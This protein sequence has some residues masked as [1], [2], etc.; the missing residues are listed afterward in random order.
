MRILL[1]LALSTAL[2]GHLLLIP[3]IRMHTCRL[4]H[5][6][7]NGDTT[8]QKMDELIL[9]YAKTRGF[10]GSVLVARRGS[11]SGFGSD[12][13][14]V[15]KDD[16]CVVVLSN[17]SGSTFNAQDLSRSLLAILYRQPYSIP[18]KWTILHLSPEELQ[19]YTGLYEFPQ[20]GFTF[21]IWVEDGSLY[22]QSANRP[23][24]RST[25]LPT[26]DDHFIAGE[27][28]DAECWIHRKAGTLTFTQRGRTFT[29]QKSK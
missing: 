15:P 24:G 25:L 19:T 5:A 10:N 8:R 22:C 16:V 9:A 4:R 21:R 2:T 13:E 20:I 14:R 18:K 3:G 6:S 29:G 7:H 12:L 1:L 28:G 17:V 26:G 27:S 11:I 23:G